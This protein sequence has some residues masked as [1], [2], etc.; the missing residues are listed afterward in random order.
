MK[1]HSFIIRLFILAVF[2]ASPIL[3]VQTNAC[4]IAPRA[5]CETMAENPEALV[6]RARIEAHIANGIQLRVFDVYAGSET[7]NIITVWNGTDFDC[8][9]PFPMQAS[10][11]G[12]VGDT[13]IAILPRIES[14]ENIW[15]SLGDYRASL[16]WF[17]TPFLRQTGE[18]INGYF[19]DPW[20]SEGT[21]LTEFETTYGECS[22]P[23]GISNVPD[24]GIRICPN[25]ASDV[26]HLEWA[27]LPASGRLEV[28]DMD[29]RAVKR[30]DV[31]KDGK[32]A[33]FIHDLPSGV[34]YLRGRMGKET[35]MERFAVVR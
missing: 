29:G 27:R 1:N 19:T 11:F 30:I 16:F 12:A 23:V 35:I 26:L 9:G 4:D 6:T 2:F 22:V 17:N 8:N 18:M 13:I 3:A 10:Q 28:Y 7:A 5:F 32:T 20:T 21:P 25:P 14:L 34:Y 24:M 33:I 31:G 15:E